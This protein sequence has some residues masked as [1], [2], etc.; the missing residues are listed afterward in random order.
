MDNI[1]YRARPFARWFERVMPR[2]E[3]KFLVYVF[4]SKD[5][6]P[7]YVGCTNTKSLRSRMRV[8]FDKSHW[9][10]H[11][12]ARCTIAD[13]LGS[14][15][16]ALERE[17]LRIV[18]LQPKYN[19][20]K[21]VEPPSPKRKHRKLKK[22]PPPEEYYV[23]RSEPDPCPDKACPPVT[24]AER[25]EITKRYF[26]LRFLW[27]QGGRGTVADLANDFDIPYYKVR[28]IAFEVLDRIEPK[29]Y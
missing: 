7:L 18:E 1:P 14:K 23:V 8:H 19:R 22:V 9:A 12:A 6:L 16:A 15:K 26:K 28:K 2:K 29:Q 10:K 11:E 4:W 21:T 27:Q 24:E 5:N 17:W 3:N 20:N 13:E 25:I